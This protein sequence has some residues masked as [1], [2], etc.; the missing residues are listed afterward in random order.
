MARTL[1]Q[2]GHKIVR[3]E[4]IE[5]A[6]M[7]IS[8]C[9]EI[10]NPAESDKVIQR[11]VCQI[12]TMA[13]CVFNAHMPDPFCFLPN[14]IYAICMTDKLGLFVFGV[15]FIETSMRKV[16]LAQ[17]EDDANFTKLL[18]L[19]TMYPPDLVL[20]ERDEDIGSLIGTLTGH[21]KNVPVESLSPYTEF[22]SATDTLVILS[23]ACYFRDSDG[24][25]Q[26]PE[27]FAK[28]ADNR[29]PK[30]NAEYAI[31][32]LGACVWYLQKSKIDINVFTCATF[33]WYEPVD[34][35]EDKNGGHEFMILDFSTI[36]S[37]KLIGDNE[38]CTDFKKH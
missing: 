24:N 12:T 27:I 25:L 11:E 3:V 28:I 18:N 22:L 23:R 26:W 10:S 16:T 29:I 17:F 32:S 14:Y 5:T 4:E 6:E 35:V 31:K 30:S 1:L 7:M 13:T 33:S 15:C 38:T 19:L 9:A 21:F 37:L 34:T 8:R 20:L 2:S 36:T